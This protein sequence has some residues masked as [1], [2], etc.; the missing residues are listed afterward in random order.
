[1]PTGSNGVVEP[2]NRA[3]SSIVPAIP[4]SPFEPLPPQSMLALRAAV[5][6][7]GLDGLP[8]PH[9]PAAAM[10]RARDINL[11]SPGDL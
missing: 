2:H 5:R 3:D 4:S 10:V 6:Q 1:M 8:A 11:A 7:K 9:L